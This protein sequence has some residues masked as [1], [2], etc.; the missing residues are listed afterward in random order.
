MRQ[1]FEAD[2]MLELVTIIIDPLIKKVSK[3]LTQ[4]QELAGKRLEKR[5]A[6]STRKYNCI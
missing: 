6:G 2:T 1:F 3:N 5:M 4:T